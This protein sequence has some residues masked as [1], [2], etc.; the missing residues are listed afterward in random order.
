MGEVMIVPGETSVLLVPK[1]PGGMLGHVFQ[2]KPITAQ[3]VL[4]NFYL[5]AFLFAI[6][7]GTITAFIAIGGNNIGQGNGGYFTGTL[8]ITYVLVALTMSSYLV[9]ALRPHKALCAAMF[10]YL[11]YIAAY[12]FF[13]LSDAELATKRGVA[14]FFSAIA[15]ISAGFL[16]TAQGA[17][18][19]QSAKHY[20]KLTGKNLATVTRQMAGGFSALYV[21]SEFVFK[22]ATSP[23][24][25]Q[26]S[27]GVL[28]VIYGCIGA[29]AAVLTCLF[30]RDIPMES[31]NRVRTPLSLRLFGRKASIAVQLIAKSRT[32]LLIIP[33]QIAFGFSAT[34]FNGTLSSTVLKDAGIPSS[35]T[36]YVTSATPAT[37]LYLSIVIGF[38]SPRTGNGPLLI[39]GCI[40]YT[41]IPIVLVAL[42]NSQLTAA[43]YGLIGFYCVQGVGRV[44]FESS[45]KALLSESFPKDT[46][47][48]FSNFIIWSG[49]ASGIGY[50][51]YPHI[52]IT[53]QA[54]ITLFFASLS[55]ISITTLFLIKRFKP[56]IYFALGDEPEMEGEDSRL[57]NDEH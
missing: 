27:F 51:L 49:T 24:S 29:G 25:K 39:L 44:M 16:W 4:F 57:V 43:G 47:A 26:V 5:L 42:T 45:N 40:C 50:F 55:V 13:N 10:I 30:V 48:A 2:G 8:Y 28:A 12:L 20:S 52:S 15:G 6:N 23:I 35:D 3:G 17:F 21:G 18:F 32:L 14:I 41:L 38:I 46:E 54:I 53:W 9:E 36:G 34:F 37:A 11:F 7:H 31:A 56:Q 19:T 22:L 33:L 1:Q